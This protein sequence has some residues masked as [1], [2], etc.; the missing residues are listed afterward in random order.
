MAGPA[1]MT[2]SAFA[3][4]MSGYERQLRTMT[5]AVLLADNR[6]AALTL[7]GARACQAA[8]AEL[9]AVLVRD[10][11]GD[12]AVI[13]P[14]SRWSMATLAALSPTSALTAQLLASVASKPRLIDVPGSGLGPAMVS[15]VV[16]SKPISAVLLVARRSGAKPFTESDLDLLVPYTAEAGLA[17][18]FAEA[19]RELERDVLAKD[20][21]RIARE[22]HD[23][24][25]QSLYGI[26]LVI[27]G[28]RSEVARPSV[29]DQLS[30]L[31]ESIN[32]LIDDLRA[33]IN[34]L[35]PTRLAK[36]G[37]GSEMLS[38]A[39]EFQASTGVVA[40]VRLHEHVDEIGAD[41]GRDLVQIAREAL[42]N[43]AKHAAAT[44]VVISLRW[45]TQSIRL[46]V[47]DDGTGIAPKHTRG[48]GL[49]NMLRR[50]Q[51]WGGRVE[52]GPAHGTG[53]AVRVWIPARAGEAARSDQTDGLLSRAS[54]LGIAVSAALAIAG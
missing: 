15:N 16:S 37:L 1:T 41:L 14:T 49:P 53:T 34:D 21:N 47:S 52:I 24:V 5:R 38:L 22:L 44:R 2:Q 8:G 33:Y 3:A 36:R 23:G 20:R 13:S 46:D 31:T 12:D 50:V 40:T 19:R 30:G 28:V 4:A 17:I 11:D 9:G 29:K 27:E 39:K 43:V 51:A 6:R 48:R 45:T 25:I 54:V 7:V 26:G 42:A 35:T 10:I 32:L 18:M